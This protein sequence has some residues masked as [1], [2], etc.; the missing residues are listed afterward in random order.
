M[1]DDGV[2]DKGQLEELLN[3]TVKNNLYFT[4]ALVC[5]IDNPEKIAF[6]AKKTIDTQREELIKEISIHLMGHL[7]IGELLKKMVI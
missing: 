6:G 2:A 5:N 7:F 4:N 3:K 1:D